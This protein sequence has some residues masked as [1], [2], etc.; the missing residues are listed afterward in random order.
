[1]GVTG[2]GLLRLGWAGINVSYQSKSDRF[3]T[4]KPSLTAEFNP[5]NPLEQG[6]GDR[7]F[8]EI[9]FLRREERRRKRGG[10]EEISL[11]H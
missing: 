1:V 4:G 2:G 5:T 3:D 7:F 8:W 9:H 11:S 6:L 10:D